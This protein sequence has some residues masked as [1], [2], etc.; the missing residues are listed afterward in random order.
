MPPGWQ[1]AIVRDHP[2]SLDAR[3]FNQSGRC[4]VQHRQTAA[5]VSRPRPSAPPPK[6]RRLA[7]PIGGTSA[8]N[9]GQDP[10]IPPTHAEEGVGTSL[11]ISK[12]L[13]VRDRELLVG[14]MTRPPGLAHVGCGQPDSFLHR[15]RA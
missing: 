11:A 1:H 13:K 10:T 5:V 7:Q 8:E 15:H 14:M 3:R 4:F 9:P 12:R 2:D 6:R